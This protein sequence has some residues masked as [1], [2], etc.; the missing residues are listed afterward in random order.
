MGH[1]HRITIVV[2]A[3]AST[4]FGS[5]RSSAGGSRQ[6]VAADDG[7]KATEAGTEVTRGGASELGPDSQPRTSAV[8]LPPTASVSR[9]C[10]ALSPCIALWPPLSPS[11]APL[12]A[13]QESDLEKSILLV[14]ANKQDMKGALNAGACVAC[15]WCLRL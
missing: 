15:V 7:Y 10:A 1:E 4:T 6:A 9:P 8:S 5:G 12:L 11:R 13:S 14:F 2:A 3:V